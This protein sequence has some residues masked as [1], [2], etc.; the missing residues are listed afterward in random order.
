MNAA[1][2]KR[3]KEKKM[4]E[5]IPITTKEQFEE[6][7]KER[8]S[9]AVEE[10]SKKYEGFLSPDDVEKLKSEYD[11]KIKNRD[12]EIAERD[13]KI[14]KYETGSLKTRIAHEMGLDYDAAGFIQ[15]EDEE[16]IRKSAEALKSLMGSSHKAP[17]LR[18]IEPSGG[19]AGNND[20]A[21]RKI[22]EN[23]EE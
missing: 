20:D 4:E 15:G 17:P 1:F 21:Y 6:T 22:L 3:G 5:F 14:R 18:T 9:L 2:I 19:S 12:S 23:M 10:C 13:A 7:I 8:I 11:D 16:A